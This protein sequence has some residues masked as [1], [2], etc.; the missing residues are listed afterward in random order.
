MSRLDPLRERQ[1]FIEAMEAERELSSQAELASHA[2]DR[3]W[4]CRTTASAETRLPS[5]LLPIFLWKL[6]VALSTIAAMVTIS[7]ILKSERLLTLASS[8]SWPRLT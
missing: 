3:S 8:V 1:E 2:Q 6:L 4:Q 7:A 5:H